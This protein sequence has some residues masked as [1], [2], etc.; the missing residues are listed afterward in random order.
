MASDMKLPS[1]LCN[2]VGNMI[3]KVLSELWDVEVL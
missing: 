1:N 2:Q 3:Y